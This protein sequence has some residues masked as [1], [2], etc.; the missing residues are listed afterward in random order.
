MRTAA[1]YSGR[2]GSTPPFLDNE[3]ATL[4]TEVYQRADTL[5]FGRR[6]YEIFAGRQREGA[7][8]EEAGRRRL[9]LFGQVDELGGHKAERG[10]AGHRHR[11]LRG[12]VARD[13]ARVVA[14]HRQHER[15]DEH[16]DEREAVIGAGLE[17]QGTP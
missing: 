6:T 5:L 9:M 4:R 2:G 10:T 14:R 11:K 8:E 1:A 3:A 7:D 13:A 16:E 17:L 15:R 12:H